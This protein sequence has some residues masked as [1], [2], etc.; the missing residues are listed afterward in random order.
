[1]TDDKI[2][3]LNRMP[4][5]ALETIPWVE[6]ETGL[7]DYRST[8][9]GRG[10]GEARLVDELTRLGESAELTDHN[11]DYDLITD[12][13]TIEVKAPDASGRIVTAGQG[14]EV[15]SPFISECGTF[16]R[17][18]EPVAEQS[19]DPDMLELFN[20]TQ[21]RLER[22]NF[23]ETVLAGVLD[24]IEHMA[25]ADG[26]WR[27]M[28]HRWLLDPSVFVS[29][30]VVFPSQCIKADHIALVCDEGYALLTK[31]DADNLFRF[32]GD[33]W[34]GRPKFFSPHA[35]RRN[36]RIAIKNNTQKTCD[37]I[38]TTERLKTDL[39]RTRKDNRHGHNS[40]DAR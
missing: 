36:R 9:A 27:S 2:V 39:K 1:L 14:H 22:G 12:F 34:G 38:E 5:V 15:L 25:T 17:M 11:T 20:D 21:R 10:S 31:F 13:G 16:L 24:V 4:R 8:S 35:T 7:V 26:P 33:A 19:F 30:I 32:Q 40:R 3:V 18:F 29:D 6:W 37:K 28:K 23:T